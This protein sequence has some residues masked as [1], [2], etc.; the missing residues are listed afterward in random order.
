MK[1]SVSKALLVDFDDLP[2][3]AF[4]RQ[5]QLLSSSVIPFSAATLWRRVRAGTFPQ[6]VH[7]SPQVTAWRVSEIRQWQKDP[8]GY[9]FK[10]IQSIPTTAKEGAA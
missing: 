4:V 3:D 2:N 6:P 9:V 5:A 1:Q 7:I 8:A 10:S